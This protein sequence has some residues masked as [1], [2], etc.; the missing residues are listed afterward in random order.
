MFAH[1]MLEIVTCSLCMTTL[2]S[3]AFSPEGSNT[4]CVVIHNGIHTWALAHDY[5]VLPSM[6]RSSLV[7]CC[8]H[9]PPQS[10][11][12]M[13]DM[14]ECCILEACH[15]PRRHHFMGQYRHSFWPSGLPPDGPD[16]RV[17]ICHWYATRLY[18]PA[19]TAG[20]PSLAK[21]SLYLQLQPPTRWRHQHSSDHTT[22]A[23]YHPKC[24]WSSTATELHSQLRCSRNGSS[25]YIRVATLSFQHQPTFGTLDD[26]TYSP[27]GRCLDEKKT[28]KIYLIKK[29]ALYRKYIRS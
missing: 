26:Y 20:S 17:A 15:F 13:A 8:C 24:S 12:W 21:P 16:P 22:S 6:A 4:C 29:Q 25:S 18:W 19:H 1:F 2:R 3:A 5:G 9:C 11:A 28:P 10:S 14:E 27:Q 7:T 23:P